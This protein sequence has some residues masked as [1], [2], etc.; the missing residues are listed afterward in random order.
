MHRDELVEDN[1]ELYERYS[2]I[3]ESLVNGNIIYGRSNRILGEN[4]NGK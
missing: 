1:T 2:L 3:Y 4:D